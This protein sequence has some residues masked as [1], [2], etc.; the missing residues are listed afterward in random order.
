MHRLPL[1]RAAML[2][3]FAA[4]AVLLLPPAAAAQEGQ[5]QELRED[6]NSPRASKSHERHHDY[7]DEDYD[8][9]GRRR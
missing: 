6:V 2:G 7:D 4:L 9:P 3:M 5:L 8:G 1:R